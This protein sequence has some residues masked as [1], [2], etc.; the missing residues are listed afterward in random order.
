MTMSDARRLCLEDITGYTSLLA[1][2]LSL[3]AADLNV[4]RRALP[5]M[6][7]IA[8]VSS[9]NQ[10][11]NGIHLGRDRD[12]YHGIDL[13]GQDGF[14]HAFGK[15]GND[16]VI[17]GQGERHQRAGDHRRHDKRQRNKAE[18]LPGRCSKVARRFKDALVH[19][20]KPCP[21][22]NGDKADAKSGVRDNDGDHAQR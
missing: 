9:I 21:H 8:S 15:E 10:C 12:L 16:K 4:R 6:M 18:S 19:A 7:I 2:S 5:A 3:L 14:A 1:K 17:D 22:D 13:D 20:L 11:G